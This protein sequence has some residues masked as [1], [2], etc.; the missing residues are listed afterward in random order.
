MKLIGE[1]KNTT[2][3]DGGGSGTC[4]Q[5][6]NPNGWLIGDTTIFDTG[7]GTY[8]SI[9]GTHTGTI[10]PFILEDGKTYNYTIITGRLVSADSPY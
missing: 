7:S 8:P 4:I 1:G 2:I 6:Q 3:I 10:T 9:S 5:I